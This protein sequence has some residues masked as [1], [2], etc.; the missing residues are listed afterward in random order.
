MYQVYGASRLRTCKIVLEGKGFVDGSFGA[1]S[2]HRCQIFG[3]IGRACQRQEGSG[4]GYGGQL[5]HT[6]KL[7]CA[8]LH[9]CAI[10][11]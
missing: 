1:G 6:V 4:H 9:S 11:S 5:L 3:Q 7:V 8:M 2:R 10:M